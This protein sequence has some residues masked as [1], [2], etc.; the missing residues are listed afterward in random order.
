M[1]TS[2]DTIDEWYRKVIYIQTQWEH[3]EEIAHWHSKPSFH[4][5]PYF[6]LIRTIHDLNAMDINTIEVPE[7]TSEEY[8]HCQ[9]KGLCFLCWKPGH[10]SFLCLFLF[11]LNLRNP[12]SSEYNKLSKKKPLTSSNWKIIMVN[13][14]WEGQPSLGIFRRR[15]LI[16]VKLPRIY[17]YV[18]IYISHKQI[19]ANSFATDCT[20]T[21][22][23]NHQCLCPDW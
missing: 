4:V 3:A 16:N 11:F 12:L 22:P 19:Y 1:E 6:A 18:C 23:E 2:P 15:T 21:H 14:T 7:L 10:L 5:Q 9:E 20:L 13:R 8:H 17:M